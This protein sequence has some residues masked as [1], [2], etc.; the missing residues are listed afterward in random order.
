[1]LFHVNSLQCPGTYKGPSVFVPEFVPILTYI[2]IKF[3][4][5]LN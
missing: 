1:M 2:P 3:S 5:F 4:N